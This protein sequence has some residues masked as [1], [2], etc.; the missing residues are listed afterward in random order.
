[1]SA[2][3]LAGFSNAYLLLTHV[4]PRASAI[5]PTAVA[6]AALAT[7]LP[8]GTLANGSGLDVAPPGTPDQGENRDAASVIW[9]WVAPG[10]R[11]VVWPSPFATH[12]IQPRLT[13]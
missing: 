9:E 3:G 11:A 1:M 2:E 12:A 13:A 4:L 8:R 10:Q 6:R 7:K 5:T